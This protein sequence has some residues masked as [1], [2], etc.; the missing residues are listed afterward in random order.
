MLVQVRAQDNSGFGFLLNPATSTVGAGTVIDDSSALV[1]GTGIGVNG[2]RLY[3]GNSV[4]VRNG[5]GVA[6]AGG[7]VLSYKTN[8]IDG[9]NMADGTPL[10]GIPLN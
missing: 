10:N 9:N 7:T 5:F 6:I 1:N 8:M 4:V 2:G 3:L